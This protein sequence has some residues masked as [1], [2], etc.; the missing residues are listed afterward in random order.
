MEKMN[1]EKSKLEAI[2][3]GTAETSEDISALATRYAAL[4]DELDEAELRWLELSEKGSA[5]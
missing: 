3:N 2:F 4:K 1:E 5:S